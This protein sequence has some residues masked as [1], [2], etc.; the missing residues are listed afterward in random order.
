MQE[1]DDVELE[2]ECMDCLPI[3]K[4]D[5]K[6]DKK[7]SGYQKTREI[8]ENDDTFKSIL[9]I[10]KVRSLDEGIFECSIRNELGFNRRKISLIIASRPRD[11]IITIDGKI[12]KRVDKILTISD[13]KD[14]TLI[15]IAN[16]SPAPTITWLKNGEEVSQETLELSNEN[17]HENAGSYQCIVENIH[18]TM[19]KEIQVKVEI[20]P[21]IQSSAKEV[22]SIKIGEKT[23]LNCDIEGSPVPMF[24]WI[25]N[26]QPLGE[27]KEYK[28]LKGKKVLEFK[29]AVD[30]VGTYSCTGENRFGKTTKTFNV[31]VL[32]E[33]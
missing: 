19:S 28:L 8:D 30:S 14:V 27:S 31:L 20:A 7:R 12:K 9:Q 5:W 24:T 21:F 26:L 13:S 29:G 32:S 10:K 2:C 22:K 25:R 6:F 16:A 15:C 3:K 23:S 33:N 11:L 4:Y 17:M 1:N 18:G